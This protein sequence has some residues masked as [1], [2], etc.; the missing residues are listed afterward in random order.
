MVYCPPLKKE[1]KVLGFITHCWPL[2]LTAAACLYLGVNVAAYV[3]IATGATGQLDPFWHAPLIQL[4][5]AI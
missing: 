5:Q 2:M 3:A 1:N 4:L